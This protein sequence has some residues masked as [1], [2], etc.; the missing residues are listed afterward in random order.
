MSEALLIAFITYGAKYGIPAVMALIETWNKPNPSVE[1]WKAAFA[2]AQAYEVYV[3]PN[4]PV[5]PPIPPVTP[6]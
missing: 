5:K 3:G 2:V 6:S 1:D 4:P